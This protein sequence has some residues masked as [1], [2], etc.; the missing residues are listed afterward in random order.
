MVYPPS[1]A[2]LES[3]STVASWLM[4]KDGIVAKEV[5]SCTVAAMFTISSKRLET[6][7]LSVGDA[8]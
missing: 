6:G 5:L 3:R 1:K 4:V 8:F 2:L 7:F